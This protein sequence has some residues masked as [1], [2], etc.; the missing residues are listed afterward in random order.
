MIQK[1][2]ELDADFVLFVN[3]KHT[4]FL[5]S[6]FYTV[7][8]TWVWV[9]LYILLLLLVV[10]KF[11]SR[12]WLV[13]LCIALLITLSDQFASGLMKNLVMRY[14]PSHN[15]ILGPQLH[16]VRDY[17]GG[18]YGFMSSH[19]ANVFALTSFLTFIFKEEKMKWIPLLWLWATV[20]A[21]S[22]IYLGVH[23]LSDIIGGAL[24]GIFFA[25]VVS[26]IFFSFNKKLNKENKIVS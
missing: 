2:K 8:Q 16:I 3:G 17:T 7:S 9:P 11:Q 20:V 13:L 22:R 6:F 14:R 18:L 5:D 24:V 25:W 4:P 12:S 19:A 26:K 21:F 10:R 15:I 23:Y 1:L